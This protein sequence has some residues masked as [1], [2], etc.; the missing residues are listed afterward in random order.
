M[1]KF[2]II[3]KAYILIC[4]I[5]LLSLFLVSC[6]EKIEGYTK[7]NDIYINDNST[8]MVLI[9]GKHA[10]AM[11]IPED[12]YNQI[13]KMLD[14]TDYGGYVCAVIVDS[15]PTKVELVK[16]KNFF[17]ED[18]KNTHKL[19]N[20]INDRKTT[21]FE[22]LK[23]LT[24]VADSEEVDLL[25]AIREAKNALSNSQA[26]NAK[27]KEIVI[28]DTGISTI[29]DLNFRDLDFLYGKP[30][31]NEIVQQLE[32]YEGV[33]VLPDL[34]GVD[35][36]FI[37]TDDGL[38][39]VA[40]PQEATTA[41]KKF[42]REL[43]TSV[44]TACG[45]NNIEFERAAGWSVPNVYTED[46]ETRFQFVSVIPFFH[47]NVINFEE[48]P[49][50]NPDNSDQ[51]PNL[52]DPPIVEIK[53]ESQTVGFEPDTAAYIS[54]E[55]AKN[56]LRPYADELKDFFK[57]YPDEKIWIV[58]TTAA[59]VKGSRD[60]Y[61]LSFKRAEAVKNMLVNEYGIPSNKLFTIGVGCVFPWWVDEF[62]S[63][64]FDTNVAQANRAV[65]LL[66]NSD[67]GDYFDKLKHAY[68][69]NELLPET[70]SRFASIYN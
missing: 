70:M 57:Y 62:T 43:W 66:S 58:G 41:D 39:E 31:I 54:E 60:G 46:D 8:A 19:K 44:I 11:E 2:I 5:F 33:G 21:I 42:I 30:N 7:E 64:E 68:D 20:E 40:E 3:Q 53:L 6:E 29:G 27:N 16:D 15:N 12:A 25:A 23:E 51:P 65:F 10:N 35:V 48:I 9:L 24:V 37:G 67:S 63:G 18:A 47:N 59:V 13:E 22:S 32:D 55:N 45:A 52:P 17:M 69:N 1:K 36:T 49:V 50:Y 28:I 26:K 38:A 4:I 14:N 61:D 56:I 34:T